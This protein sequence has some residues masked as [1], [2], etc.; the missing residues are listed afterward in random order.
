MKEKLI[1]SLGEYLADHKD[2][3][4]PYYQRGYIWGKSRGSEKDSVQFLLESINGHFNDKKDLFLQGMTICESDDNIELIDGQQRTTFFYLLLCYLKYDKL[5]DLKYPIRI[6][7]QHFLDRL[8]SMSRNE[9][10]EFCHEDETEGFQDIYYF[11]KTIRSIHEMLE[12]FNE[13]QIMHLREY[14]LEHIKFL[15][16][17]IPKEKATIVFS[18]MNGSKA[19]MH[20]EEIIKAE[21]LRLVSL[22][23]NS[24]NNDDVDAV[25]WEQNLLRSKYAREW[26]KWQYW[27]NREEVSCFY[28]TKN[29]M[30]LLIRTYYDSLK[31]VYSFENFRDLC[32]KG[33]RKNAKDT[34]YKLRHL[35]KR[36]EDVYNNYELHNKVGAILYLLSEN[37]R[38][39]FIRSYFSEEKI[40]KIDDYYKYV[41][42]SASHTEIE[43]NDTDEIL[44]LKKEE[45]VKALESDN[46]YNE[47]YDYAFRQ[48]LRLNIDA[49]TQLNRCF[50]FSIVQKKSLE[51]IHPQ[52]KVYHKKDGYCYSDKDGNV[53]EVI[54]PGMIDKADFENCS[55]HCIGNLVLLYK[56]ENSAFSN[57]DFQDKKKIY[58]DLKREEAF[59]S[60]HLLHSL[61]VFAKSEWGKDQIKE[62]KECIIKEI[63]NYYGIQ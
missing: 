41:F 44:Q 24:L 14:L 34:F 42:L 26:D 47:A 39:K 8:K 40:D 29:V 38:S 11:K 3:V 32:L 48:L 52:S 55:Q 30:G 43:K 35:Q 9:I 23:D 45:V 62:N 58:F 46:L 36:F 2:I 56:N 20:T 28:H 63:R 37:D 16:I 49:D 13:E 57:K 7:S 6:E 19:E 10:V 60:R 27:W 33:D 25:R 15:F 51:H 12:D 18:M 59:K 4:I 22:E 5:F 54:E 17:S 50:D 31:N 1:S 61:S 21:I 53:I